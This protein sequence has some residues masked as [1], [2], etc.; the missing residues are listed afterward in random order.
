MVLTLFEPLLEGSARLG[1]GLDWKTSLQELTAAEVLGV[2]EYAVE[3]SGP[4][5]AKTFRA[6]V[7]SSPASRWGRGRPQQEGGG[8][9]C[10]R[11]G[12]DGAAATRRRRPQGTTSTTSRRR[13]PDRR[14]RA[15]A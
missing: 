13:R 10:R 4:D 15:G 1:A 11:G 7:R 9:A 14:M 12:L 5:H 8:A 6:A 2:P 3:E